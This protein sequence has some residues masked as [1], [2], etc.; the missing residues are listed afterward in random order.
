MIVL[1]SGA[2]LA[3]FLACV[4]VQAVPVPQVLQPY[5]TLEVGVFSGIFPDGNA[6]LTGTD[7]TAGAGYAP[8]G[9][10]TGTQASGPAGVFVSLPYATVTVTITQ[11]AAA[12]SCAAP[13]SAD[14]ISTQGAK[15]GPG[16]RSTDE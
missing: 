7:G 8:T 3:F 12:Q 10:G 13:A 11:A 4:E 14:P 16:D 2:A 5:K 9:T 1:T 6:T 15:I